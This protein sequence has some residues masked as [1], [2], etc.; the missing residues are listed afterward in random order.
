MACGYPVSLSFTMYT[1]MYISIIISY[2]CINKLLIRKIKKI[3][4][5]EILKNRE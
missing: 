2:L 3:T 4:P 5:A 1:L